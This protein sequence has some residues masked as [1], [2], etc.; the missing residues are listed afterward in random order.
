MKKLIDSRMAQEMFYRVIL[1]YTTIGNEAVMDEYRKWYLLQCKPR[2][3]F[4][5]KIH[6]TNQGYQ[7]FHPRLPLKKNLV[8]QFKPLRWHQPVN[9]VLFC[10]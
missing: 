9:S 3:S 1:G 4:R 10:C 2:E 5:A 6:L 7:C 8:T